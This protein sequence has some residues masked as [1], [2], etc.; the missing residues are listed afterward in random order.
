MSRTIF[1]DVKKVGKQGETSEKQAP[2]ALTSGELARQAGCRT[3]HVRHFL[4][5]RNIQPESTVAHYRIYADEVLTRL[6]EY[7]A[8][9]KGSA[10][11]G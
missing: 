2:K 11:A 7:L 5:S 3:H 10:A 4:D 8:G 6:K 1:K 9:R